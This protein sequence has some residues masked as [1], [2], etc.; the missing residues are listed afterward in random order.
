MIT[1]ILL[2]GRIKFATQ[3]KNCEFLSFLVCICA[4]GT[5]LPPSLIYKFDFGSFQDIWL[6]NWNL[7]EITYFSATINRWSCGE[8]DFD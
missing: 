6:E 3:N 2:S 8:L 1:E 7:E 5:Y 4:D